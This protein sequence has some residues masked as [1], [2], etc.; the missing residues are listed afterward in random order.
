[1]DDVQDD[2]LERVISDIVK[3]VVGPSAERLTPD[4][5]LFVYG[6]DSVACIQ[7]RHTV[8]RLLTD[9]AVTLPLTVVQDSGTIHCLALD[10]HHGI[11]AVAHGQEV[12]MMKLA[13]GS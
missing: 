11:L 10:K 2:Q 13:Q 9:S 12:H 3:N 1:M 6:V 5:D 8:S 4:A 7:I